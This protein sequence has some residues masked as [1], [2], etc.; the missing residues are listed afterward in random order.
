[1]T[2]LIFSGMVFNINVGFSEL[3]NKEGKD[4][5]SKNYAL[6]IGDTVMVNEVSPVTIVIKVTIVTA[7]R[8]TL[9]LLAIL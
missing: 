1:M 3:K 8:T 7:V 9:C 6:F 2:W 4:E 5:G